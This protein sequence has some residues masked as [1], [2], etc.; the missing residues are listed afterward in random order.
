MARKGKQDGLAFDAP[1]FQI[2]QT[3]KAD[4]YGVVRKGSYDGPLP[5]G[6]L[7][8]LTDAGTINYRVEEVRPV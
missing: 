8:V 3:V 2:G 7:R 6:Y 1:T 5:S 4:C